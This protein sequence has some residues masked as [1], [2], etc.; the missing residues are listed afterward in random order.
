MKT[1]WLAVWAVAV[2]GLL[3]LGATATPST[4]EAMVQLT[5]AERAWLAA[6]PQVRWGMD[7]DWPPFSGFDHKG[8]LVGIDADITRLV[9]ARVGLRLTIIRTAA[10]PEMLA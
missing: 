7:P 4:Q 3:S 6:H 1:M 8:Q 5:P 9:A 10:W 2:V